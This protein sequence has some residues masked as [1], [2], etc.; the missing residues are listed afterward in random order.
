MEDRKGPTKDCRTGLMKDRKGLAKVL[1]LTV[2]SLFDLQDAGGD[3]LLDL[4][5]HHGVLQVIL[6]GLG[7]LL[8]VVQH[9]AHDGVGE[10]LLDLR[11]LHGPLLALLLLLRRQLTAVG[12]VHHVRA[13]LDALL[14][15][16]VVGISALIQ[17]LLVGL[18][19]FVVILHEV[20]HARLARVPLG[21]G[22]VYGDALLCV[23]L[24]LVEGHQLHVARASIG[25]ELVVRRV[26]L[27]GLRVVLHRIREISVFK[28]FIALGLLLFR[29]FRVKVRFLR[30]LLQPRLTLLELLEG[31]GVAVLS[32]R[33]CVNLDCCFHVPLLL[34]GCALAGH[35][36]SNNLVV[37]ADLTSL[38]DGCLALLDALIEVAHLQVHRR[39]IGDE[40]DVCSVKLD[41]RLV[42]L[43]GFFERLLLVRC[44]AQFLL[45]N[46]V[47]LALLCRFLLI[48]LHGFRFRLPPLWRSLLCSQIDAFALRKTIGSLY[49]DAEQHA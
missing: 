17:A 21:E 2:I 23:G 19:G 46:G 18:D 30:I 11:V 28:E 47:L 37:C 38:L 33:L 14:Q 32:E 9:L 45:L 5:Q 10:D 48:G 7:V 31:V 13:R 15:L 24:R 29:Q 8:H 43:D 27:N 26:A 35:G 12:R 36:L 49:V 25:V 41:G 20:L 6:R 22:R 39:Q 42:V 34:Q 40:G 4:A 3:Q 1:Q 44:V 16:L